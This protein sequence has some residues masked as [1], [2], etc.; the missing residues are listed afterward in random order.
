[1]PNLGVQEAIKKA[2]DYVGVL[3]EEEPITDIGLEEVEHDSNT[4]K[5]TIGFNRV[6]KNPTNNVIAMMTQS[7]AQ[8]YFKVVT[9]SDADGTL[10]SIKNRELNS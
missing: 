7:S 6:W 4:W 9:I 3:F 10:I 1:M 8:R 5:I 2:R